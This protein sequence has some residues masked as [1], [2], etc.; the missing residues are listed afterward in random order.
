M[1]MNKENSTEQKPRIGVTGLGRMGGAIATRLSRL[2]FAVSGWTRSGIDAKRAQGLGLAASSS[3]ADL[4][5]ASDILMLSL[6]D[7]EAVI[8]VLDALCRCAIGGKLIVDTSTVSPDTLRARAGILGQ[9]G[10]AAIDAPISGGPGLVL[11]G[12]AGLL[13]GGDKA[14]VDRFMSVALSLGER[15]YHVGGLGDGAAAKIVNNMMLCGYW[16]CLKEA[17]QVGKRAGLSA[18]IMLRILSNSPAANGA[19]TSR[20]PIIL[21]HSNEVGFTVSGAVKDASLFARTAAQY[22]VS[23]PAIGAALA[24]FSAHRD[25]GHGEDD[26]ATMVLAAYREA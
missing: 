15:V 26:L 10:G 7:D 11:E 14:N 22:G 6:S 13:I 2:G 4:V 8:A 20:M 16:Q 23:A 19:L 3:L 12:K 9:A 24:S 21:G 18:E 5:A 25:S 17:L 1:S